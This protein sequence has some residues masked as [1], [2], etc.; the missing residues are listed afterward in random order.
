[1]RKS[2]LQR[3]LRYTSIRPSKSNRLIRIQ[4]SFRR[5]LAK[6]ALYDIMIS[7]SYKP[8]SK[9]LKSSL[10]NYRL[11]K[12]SSKVHAHLNQQK[13]AISKILAQASDHIQT[14]EELY[15]QYFNLAHIS[16]KLYNLNEKKASQLD[17]KIVFS[18]AH[19]LA[20]T[21]CA[22]CFNSLK[23]KSN[24][25]MSCGH[26]FHDKCIE[27]LEKYDIHKSLKCPMCRAEY[28]RVPFMS[29]ES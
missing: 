14:T 12:I 27:S 16:S 23:M 4:Q 24:T 3:E 6:K 26:V 28:C 10:I 17:W 15:T 18:K 22:I 13:I 5:R 1:M 7:K 29:K 2:H 8:E 25:L 9:K 20:Q 21:E 11:Y 19:S